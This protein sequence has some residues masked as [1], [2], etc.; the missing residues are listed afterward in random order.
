MLSILLSSKRIKD[1][2]LWWPRHWYRDIRKNHAWMRHL[3]KPL[4]VSICCL[5]AMNCTLPQLLNC[6]R[7][8]KS[9]LK[10]EWDLPQISLRRCNL[11]RMSQ[12]GQNPP[13]LTKNPLRQI[14]YCAVSISE[15]SRE[16]ADPIKRTFLTMVSIWGHDNA[17]QIQPIQMVYVVVWCA[18]TRQWYK[19]HCASI[20]LLPISCPD[21]LASHTLE[22][23]IHPSLQ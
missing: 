5:H 23:L 18:Q 17:T 14:S 3:V 15:P 16:K 2:T 19:K 6:Q 4:D 21:I 8:I 9:M 11:N 1:L 20:P 22:V 12:Y 7:M 13:K 10:E